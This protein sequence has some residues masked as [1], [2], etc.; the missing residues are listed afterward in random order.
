MAKYNSIQ[1]IP[2]LTFFDILK[3]RNYQLLKPKPRENDLEAVFIS[4]YDEFFI[5][6]NNPEA[7][8]YL[9][10]TKTISYNTYKINLLK[11]SLR[12]YIYNRTTEKMRNDFIESVKVGYDIE[13][14]KDVPFI[15][16]VKRVLSIEIGILKNDLSFAENELE[17]L[18]K[19]SKGKDFDYFERIAGLGEVL[20]GNQLVKEE[21]SLAVY[22]SLENLA[23]KKMEKK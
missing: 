21:M 18:T 17:S 20:Q 22:V 13:I 15:D 14:N 3:S 16:E 12:F 7:K 6:S 2:A 4:I 1:T 19:K 23:I 10:L 5:K 9:E 8:Q 11:Q